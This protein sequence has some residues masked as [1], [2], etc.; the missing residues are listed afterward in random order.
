[1][2]LATDRLHVPTICFDVRFC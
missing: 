2:V 1:M